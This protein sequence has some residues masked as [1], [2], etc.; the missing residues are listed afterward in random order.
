MKYI[1][2]KVRYS[3]PMPDGTSKK[4][5][6]SYIVNAVSLADA[7]YKVSEFIS[8]KRELEALSASKSNVN[9]CF[10]ADNM[11]GDSFFKARIRL[12]VIDEETGKEVKK[13]MVVLVKGRDFED[14]SDNLKGCLS[15]TMSSYEVLSVSKSSIVDAI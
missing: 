9:K 12:V 11:T 6:E 4:T 5:H 3:E 15:D 7:E 14:A 2:V 13:T 10:I 1:E 8:D